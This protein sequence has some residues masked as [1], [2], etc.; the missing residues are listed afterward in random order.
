MSAAQTA[1]GNTVP[2]ASVGAGDLVRDE[3]DR[4]VQVSRPTPQPGAQLR[5]DAEAPVLLLPKFVKHQR[6]VNHHVHDWCCELTPPG[7]SVSSNL[8][9]VTRNDVGVHAYAATHM[10]SREHFEDRH[11]I[12]YGRDN[13]LFR[14]CFGVFGA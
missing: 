5:A 9:V 10:G 2:H 6:Q 13:G 1:N 11:A 7:R 12:V 3:S 8:A 4:V 14:A